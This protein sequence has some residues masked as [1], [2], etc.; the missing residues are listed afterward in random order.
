MQSAQYALT[1]KSFKLVAEN[2][3]A[4]LKDLR[5][6]IY[7]TVTVRNGCVYCHEWR[8]LGSRS[9][10]V[11]ASDGTAHGGFAL[12]L[13]SYPAEVWKNFIFDQNNGAAKIGASPNPVAE[14]LRQPLYERSMRRVKRTLRPQHNDP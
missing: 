1:E 5:G 6:D 3:L 7:D 4:P 12:P 13:E 14:E 9:H 8:G 10:H 11:A 2:P